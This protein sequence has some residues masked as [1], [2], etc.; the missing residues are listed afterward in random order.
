MNKR[1]GREYATVSED[2]GVDYRTIAETMT[3]LGHRMNHSSARN[4]VVR[5]MRK[6]VDAYSRAWGV[7]LSD[8]Q[9]EEIA[10]SPMFQS[11][12]YG[13]IDSLTSGR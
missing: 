9:A 12:V 5:V 8:E 13:A 7:R 3:V 11:G 4:H 1:T 10:K 2:E 6:F